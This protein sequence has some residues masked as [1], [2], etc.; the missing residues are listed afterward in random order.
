LKNNALCIVNFPNKEFK[1]CAEL[2]EFILLLIT[3][4]AAYRHSA[5]EALKEDWIINFGGECSPDERIQHHKAFEELDKIQE[6]VTD[7]ANETFKFCEDP[8]AIKDRLK[9]SSAN[10]EDVLRMRPIGREFSR[11]IST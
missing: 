1:N 11:C 9:C 8:R 7:I 6:I 2:V 4:N 5:T 10:L 3:P